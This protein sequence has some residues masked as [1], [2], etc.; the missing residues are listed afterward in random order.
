M[1]SLCLL[2][3]PP[4]VQLLL[5]IQTSCSFQSLQRS[6]PALP[7]HNH[8]TT[9]CVTVCGLAI[10]ITASFHAQAVS[11]LQY[12]YYDTIHI[13]SSFGERYNYHNILSI[14]HACI[15][16]LCEML[17]TCF[18]VDGGRLC[19][20]HEPALP[21]CQHKSAQCYDSNWYIGPYL[22]RAWMCDSKSYFV[23]LSYI[24]THFTG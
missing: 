23:L 22:W 14:E 6:W 5:P 9:E 11:Y 20:D 18:I 12:Y 3:S 15:I 13:S 17:C 16:I 24:N 1:P 7:R 21:R 8:V 4:C 19:I 10:E 2:L